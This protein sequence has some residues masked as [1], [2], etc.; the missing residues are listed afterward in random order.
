VIRGKWVMENIL[1]TPPPPP[2]P[3]VP[4]L[5]E[6]EP[7]RAARS[8]RERLAQHRE[9]P[10]CASCHDVLDPI[11]LALENYDA[12][13]QWRVRE[14]GGEIDA[15]GQLADG[16]VVDGVVELREA[17]LRNPEGFASVVTEK[18][19]TYALG[20]GI[21]YFD[22]PAVRAIVSEAEDSDFRFSRLVMG[23]A[24]SDQFRMR[25]VPPEISVATN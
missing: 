12:V 5:D 11:G 18:L 14:P 1:G 4:A 2:L 8:V 23:V 24:T 9:N 7:G 6:N 3:N 25:Q 15:R 10:V 22:M 21:E 20:R 13:G 19:M 17:I 16:A